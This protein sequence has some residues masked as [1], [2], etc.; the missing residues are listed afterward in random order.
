MADIDGR[1][2]D[3]IAA[4]GGI[5]TKTAK[6]DLNGKTL[7]FVKQEGFAVSPDEAFTNASSTIV[8]GQDDERAD[9]TANNDRMNVWTI[10][11]DSSNV[12]TL[13]NTTD[14]NSNDYIKVRSGFK[15][16]SNF[17]FYPVSP[18]GGLRYVN[19]QYLDTTVDTPSKFDGGST[20]FISNVDSYIPT[21]D[22]LD[23][24]VLYPRHNI[25]GNKD[26]IT[27]G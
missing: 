20:R 24:Y 22:R 27:N 1:T 5:D 16:G 17:L 12:V 9:S 23:K 2:L 7:V 13:T 15:Y 18:I 3:Y 10:S 6:T 11:V 26:Y 14:T 8:D 19:W 4:R 25:L 21:D